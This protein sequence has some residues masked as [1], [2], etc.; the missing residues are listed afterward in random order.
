MG[1]FIMAAVYAY[2]LVVVEHNN[3]ETGNIIV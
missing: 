1:S 2:A 3:L